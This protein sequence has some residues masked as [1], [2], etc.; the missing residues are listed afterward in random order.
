MAEDA[1]IAALKAASVETLKRLDGQQVKGAVDKLE[2]AGFVVI[3]FVR[4]SPS[5]PVLLLL[6]Y[7]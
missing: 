7:Y 6:L 4:F 3:G 1:D 5:T 2:Q